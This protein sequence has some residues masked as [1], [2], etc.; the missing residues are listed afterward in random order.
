MRL[1]AIIRGCDA[2]LVCVG[3]SSTETDDRNAPSSSLEHKELGPNAMRELRG[4]KQGGHLLLGL[5]HVIQS[6]RLA[7]G[8]YPCPVDET[9]ALRC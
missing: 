2:V 1:V 9:G 5:T 7:F 6:T 3:R 4:A 8:C